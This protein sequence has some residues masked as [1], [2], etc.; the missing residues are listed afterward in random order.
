MFSSES[1]GDFEKKSCGMWFDCETG[2][3]KCSVVRKIKM[4]VTVS[5]NKEAWE[6]LYVMN[7][8]KQTGFT[9]SQ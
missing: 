5:Q 6:V 4:P 2:L 3:R 7:T 1:E 9:P 8:L